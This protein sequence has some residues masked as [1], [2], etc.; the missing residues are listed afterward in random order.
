MLETAVTWLLTQ[1]GVALEIDTTPMGPARTY[2]PVCAGISNMAK[3]NNEQIQEFFFLCG[4]GWGSSEV[5]GA[6]PVM[7]LTGSR[8]VGDPAQ[9]FIF[10]LTG[11]FLNG[12]KSTLRRSVMNP[13][14]TIKR[15]T[16]SVTIQNL[17]EF[18]G[19]AQNPAD[20]SVE[21]AQN[22]PP[23][24]ETLSASAALV[25]TSVAGAAVGQTVLTVIPTF[26]D[27]D[28]G[29][30]FVYQ[31]GDT[32]APAAAA[33]DILADGWN[34]FVNGATYE[35]ATDKKVTVAQ[36]NVATYACTGS[37]NATVVAKAAG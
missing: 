6:R 26:P 16:I 21:F 23:I 34:D 24:V 27:P 30:K 3:A 5:T 1:Y 19:D 15:E 9:D 8:I 13:D 22:G 25:V 12:R 10:S 2:A 28:A 11:K 35:I 7:T 4:K 20:I 29:C 36:I 14:G 33:G 17:Q 31:V 18:G 37:G 32:T